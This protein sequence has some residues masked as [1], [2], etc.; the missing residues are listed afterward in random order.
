MTCSIV[1]LCFIL[2]CLLIAQEKKH[3]FMLAEQ[4]KE[5]AIN[6]EYELLDPRYHFLALNGSF[7]SSE[8]PAHTE[9]S[10]ISLSQKNT[11]YVEY[12]RLYMDT[13]SIDCR[14]V[15]AGD[16][17]ALVESESYQNKAGHISERDLNSDELISATSNFSDC[18]NFIIRSGYILDTTYEEEESFPVAFG[19]FSYRDVGQTE[20]LLRAIYRPHNHYCIH[21]DASSPGHMRDALTSLVA[22]LPN[23]QLVDTA[24][25]VKWG[26]WS[27]VE[28][29][30]TCMKLLLQRPGWRYYM[31]LTG[32]EFP[33]H[34]MF[35]LVQVLKLLNDRNAAVA[36]PMKWSV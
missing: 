7:Y 27:V 11:V 3:K 33:L 18:L 9:N 30:L 36:L 15:I 31:N 22:C 20:R 35:Y 5:D 25:D 26:T 1:C 6:Q 13:H 24:I 34:S 2:I 19:I 21:Q 28:A 14:S 23:V 16:E 32:Q 10:K 12:G 8:C 17:S 29:E 4:A